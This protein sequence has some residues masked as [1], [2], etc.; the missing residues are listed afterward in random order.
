ME[1]LDE[2]LALERERTLQGLMISLTEQ[3]SEKELL[4]SELGKLQ[5]RYAELEQE[6]EMKQNICDGD[7]RKEIN[8]NHGL[9]D[10]CKHL[11]ESL[12]R[13]FSDKKLSDD[14]SA[15]LTREL[16]DK[17]SKEKEYIEQEYSLSKKIQRLEMQ[18]EQEC[19]NS[20]DYK[21]AADSMRLERNS[22]KTAQ[23]QVTSQSLQLQHELELYKVPWRILYILRLES[24]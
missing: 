20:A 8:A 15:V 9:I 7:L 17:L 19:K 18:L 4:K 16:S 14:H 1:I 6:I 22:A 2:D 13:A 5:N 21:S 23:E 3:K 12:E 11:E 24:F 10:K